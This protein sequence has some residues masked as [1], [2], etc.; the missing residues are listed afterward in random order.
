MDLQLINQA[1]SFLE[2]VKLKGNE[3]P[4]FMAVVHGLQA[5]GKAEAIKEQATHVEQER[6]A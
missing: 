6:T 2:R 4:A 5:L 1:L 3:A